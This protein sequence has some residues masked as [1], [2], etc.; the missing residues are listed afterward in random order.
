MMKSLLISIFSL[1]LLLSSS[2]AF[3]APL[4]FAYQNRIVDALSII[5]V[6]Q[7]FFQAEG[8]AIVPV[9][10]SSGAATAEALHTGSVDIATMGD[11]AALTSVSKGKNI[12]IFMSHG[13]G[14][15]RHR[16]MVSAGSSLRDIQQLRGKR[17]GV[18]KGTSTH[19][20]LL[21]LFE[22]NGI[23]VKDVT[24]VDLD[25]DL[26]V[27]ALFSSTIDAIVASEPT[28]SLAE[29]RG[30]RQLAT[31]G[32][33]ANSYPVFMLTRKELL[34]S[35]AVDMHK[36]VRALQRAERFMKQNPS[37]ALLVI[38]KKTG[39]PLAMTKSAVKRHAFS[40]SM[41]K[42][43]RI[44]LQKTADFLLKERRLKAPLIVDNVIVPMP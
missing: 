26:A 28:P 20:G 21:A 11:T 23:D 17:I 18:K 34:N 25:P 8:L 44:S 12:R 32:G 27:E 37:K 43:T 9:F 40:A 7:G 31:L 2:L 1:P 14:E 15:H 13:Q 4:Q 19:G 41:D 16:I 33:L 39:L 10:L 24:V 36:F 42:A 6:E 22:K 35:R 30:A 29:G 38:S 3:A 5:A